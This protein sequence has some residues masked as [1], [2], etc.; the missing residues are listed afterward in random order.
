MSEKTLFCTGAGGFVGR[1]LLSRYLQREQCDIYLLEQG[2]FRERLERF[3]A[4]EI[5]DEAQRRR[6]HVLLNWTSLLG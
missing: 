3:L 4:E 1:H 2:G 5:T 6:I